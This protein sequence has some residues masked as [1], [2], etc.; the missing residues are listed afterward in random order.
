[1]QDNV[2]VDVVVHGL[3]VEFSGEPVRLDESFG[4]AFGI[5][6]K[7]GMT[8]ENITWD[9][10]NHN[11]EENNLITGWLLMEGNFHKVIDLLIQKHKSQKD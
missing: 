5:E 3:D 2:T 7:I 6:K 1:M 4:H 10:H 11:L 8:C 9:V